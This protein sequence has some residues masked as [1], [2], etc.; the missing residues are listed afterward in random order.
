MLKQEIPRN[1]VEVHS[2]LMLLWMLY[3]KGCTISSK[4]RE[5]KVGL[6]GKVNYIDTW[7][8]ERSPK[9]N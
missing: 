4:H 9:S 3:G 2:K 8:I 1:C 7:L 6:F 5:P